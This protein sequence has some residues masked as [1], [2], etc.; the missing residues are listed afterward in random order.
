MNHINWVQQD[1]DYQT[2]YYVLKW[3]T[4]H[5]HE[6]QARRMA[7]SALQKEGAAL[8]VSEKSETNE[9]PEIGF[10]P[11][12]SVKSGGFAL[13]H[14]VEGMISQESYGI[15]KELDSVAIS[16]KG[17]EWQNAET[18]MQTMLQQ[19]AAQQAM[20]SQ[21]MTRQTQ[22]AQDSQQSYDSAERTTATAQTG[23][24]NIRNRLQESAAH[25]QEVYQKH[26][27][28]IKRT[29]FRTKKVEKKAVLKKGTREADR[30]ETL[31]MQAQNHYLLDSYDCNGQYHILGK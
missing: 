12:S 24:G 18:D 15:Q 13:G 26:K 6:P 16:G 3:E 20:I 9:S 29:L 21:P 2:K 14:G 27:E 4:S 30:E 23:Q 22:G 28:K 7:G 11:G 10:G 5:F 31:A 8:A 17:S 19:T 25:L 1:P